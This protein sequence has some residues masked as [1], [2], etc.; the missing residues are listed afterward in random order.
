MFTK[1]KLF[2]IVFALTAVV[3]SI[4]FSGSM[5][6]AKKSAGHRSLAVQMVERSMN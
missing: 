4:Y 6:S 1:T 2:L 5:I 3:G